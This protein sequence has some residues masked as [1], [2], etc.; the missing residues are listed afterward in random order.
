MSNDQAARLREVRDSFWLVLDKQLH[1]IDQ[2][3]Q[4]SAVL[5]AT[6]NV[7]AALLAVASSNESTSWKQWTTRVA[8]AALIVSLIAGIIAVW[9]RRVSQQHL[10][11]GSPVKSV[12]DYVSM[13]SEA[14]L[15]EQC[16]DAYTTMTTGGYASTIEFRRK[17]FRI[18][19][20]SLVIGGILIA[21]N[22]LAPTTGA[23][24]HHQPAGEHRT[25]SQSDGPRA[26]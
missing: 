8:F 18:Q 14:F 6:A 13:T 7:L 10:P 9:P 16:D 22:S 15:R 23:T 11:G 26:P 1:T 20:V 3:L 24:Q 21:I 19:T 12:D 25:V 2:L 5:L 4:R 17:V